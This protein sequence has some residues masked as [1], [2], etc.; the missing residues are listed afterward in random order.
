MIVSREQRDLWAQAEEDVGRDFYYC[1]L[2]EGRHKADAVLGAGQ[3]LP[4]PQ[5]ALTRS[6]P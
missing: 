2:S 6:G 5:Q 3:V 4:S 1:A